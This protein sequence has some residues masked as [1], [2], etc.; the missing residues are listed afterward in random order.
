MLRQQDFGLPGPCRPLYRVVSRYRARP[1]FEDH[2]RAKFHQ[3]P[4][5][6]SDFYRDQTRTLFVY[7]LSFLNANR[8]MAHICLYMNKASMVSIG[9]EPG[10]AG[11]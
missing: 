4:S 6:R 10:V 1:P 11:W 7:L 9:F 8:N 2:L 5:S 3:D